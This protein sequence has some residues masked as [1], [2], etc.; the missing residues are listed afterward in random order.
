M[1]DRAEIATFEFELD[2][3]SCPATNF[4]LE[5]Y[6]ISHGSYTRQVSMHSCDAWDSEE[7]RTTNID[8]LWLQTSA[9]G[10]FVD[11][12]A[13]QLPSIQHSQEYAS[14]TLVGVELLEQVASTESP[15]ENNTGTDIFRILQ[16]SDSV[17]RLPSASTRDQ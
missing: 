2:T 6:W 8:L 12:L 1:S 13:V 3:V 4:G 15:S 14:C 9:K 17:Q 16:T 11:S 10:L 5:R 7:S